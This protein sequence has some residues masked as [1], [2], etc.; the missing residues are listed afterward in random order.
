MLSGK[1]WISDNGMLYKEPEAGKTHLSC[2]YLFARGV[3]KKGP[4]KLS[5]YDKH[6]F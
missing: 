3:W 5:P 2:I 4:V 6:P 1:L